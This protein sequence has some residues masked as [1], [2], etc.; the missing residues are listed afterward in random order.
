[1]V[2]GVGHTSQLEHGST[3]H[4]DFY[5]CN[6][7]SCNPNTGLVYL[8]ARYYNT[9]QGRFFQKDNYAGTA[10]DP[11]AQN[12]YAYVKNSPLNMKEEEVLRLVNVIK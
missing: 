8:R 12:R 5:G 2:I 1:M 7:E 4:T 6:G 11:L 10:T 9:E 3:K